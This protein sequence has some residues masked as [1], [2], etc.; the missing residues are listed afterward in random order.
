MAIMRSTRKVDE[1][2]EV[3]VGV[4]PQHCRRASARVGR[5]SVD[6]HHRDLGKYLP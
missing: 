3:G 2:L 5:A 6:A 1:D 4:E